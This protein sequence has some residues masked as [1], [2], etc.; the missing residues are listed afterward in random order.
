M[1]ATMHAASNKDYYIV[2]C[3]NYSPGAVVLGNIANFSM[4]IDAQIQTMN[5]LG[6]GQFKSV[7]L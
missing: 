1:M 7:R 5:R 3:T 2:A 4:A 6:R